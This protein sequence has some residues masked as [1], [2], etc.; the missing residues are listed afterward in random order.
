[1]NDE[2]YGDRYLKGLKVKLPEEKEPLILHTVRNF[3]ATSFWTPLVGDIN[4]KIIDNKNNKII[5]N[6]DSI[7]ILSCSG[8]LEYSINT[9]GETTSSTKNIYLAL[10]NIREVIDR[11]SLNYHNIVEE[12]AIENI[13][14]V[15]QFD[16][17][18]TQGTTTGYGRSMYLGNQSNSGDNFAIAVAGML[19][20]QSASLNGF[21]IG[22]GFNTSKDI[23]ALS[24]KGNEINTELSS[25]YRDYTAFSEAYINYS[26]SNLNLRLGRQVL[27]TPLADSDDIRMIQNTFEAYV[28]TYEVSNFTLMAGKL[29]KW[30]GVDAGLDNRWVLTGDAG[31]WFGG[32]TY[33]SDIEINAWLYN[34]SKLTKARYTDVTYTQEIDKDMS[35]SIAGQYLKET[36]VENSGIEAKIY[37]A[38][39]ALETNTFGLNL[40]YNKSTKIET[41]A[42]F[43]GFGGG[44]MFTSMDY[45]I[46][47]EITLDSDAQAIVI[48]ASYAIS[49]FDFSFAYGNFTSEDSSATKAH[50]VEQDIALEY[51]VYD[52]IV[53]TAIYVD[54]ADKENSA[55]DWKQT[56]LMIGFDF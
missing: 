6:K 41:K 1:M 17:T 55:N 48:G 7:N 51:I 34:V 21:S 36:E 31:T 32:I 35:L 23:A 13:K 20:Y 38:S 44:A 9:K 29:E 14:P 49:D 28:A 10:E 24:G 46:I 33:S 53:A 54:F 37:G 26:Y 56:R 12:T 39:V 4:Y 52:N 18:F 43:S 40:A 3:R 25:V 8:V 19:K 16:D 5:N 15:D 22:Y 47:D 2:K 27:D 11:T 50:I 42:S 45:M 30:Q